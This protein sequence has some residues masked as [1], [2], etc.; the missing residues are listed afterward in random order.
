[1]RDI[2][3]VKEMSNILETDFEN[4]IPTLKKLVKE[5]EKQEK[6]INKLEKRIK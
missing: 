3:R 2:D 6:E 5:I 1:M 4:I